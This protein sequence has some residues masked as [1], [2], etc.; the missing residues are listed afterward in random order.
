M[1]QVKTNGVFGLHYHAILGG[2]VR[3]RGKI[4]PMIPGLIPEGRESDTHSES[5][6]FEKTGR[7]PN[8]F[9]SVFCFATSRRHLKAM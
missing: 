3:Y 6:N 8:R 9:E 4:E 7:E 1:P 2:S 5:P